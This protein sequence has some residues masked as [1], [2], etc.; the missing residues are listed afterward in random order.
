M[1]PR[2]R[3]YG[4]GKDCERM[5]GTIEKARA[6]NA[7]REQPEDET[8]LRRHLDKALA[9]IELAA[10][11]ARWNQEGYPADYLHGHAAARRGETKAGQSI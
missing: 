2:A 1:Q 11:V 9:M 6:A 8:E 7:L 10:H 4:P 3:D 5:R